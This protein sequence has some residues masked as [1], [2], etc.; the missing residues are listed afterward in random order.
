[1]N[2]DSLEKETAPARFDTKPT[3]TSEAQTPKVQVWLLP[4]LIGVHRRSSAVPEGLGDVFLHYSP[5]G[6]FSQ[7]IRPKFIP[8]G[9]RDL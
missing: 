5:H 7:R 6:T 1:M 9:D 4:A 8:I 2:A 3:V